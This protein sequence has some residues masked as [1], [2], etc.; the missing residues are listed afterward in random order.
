MA[1]QPVGA[2]A[3][4]RHDMANV[5]Q[6]HAQTISRCGEADIAAAPCLIFAA[7]RSLTRGL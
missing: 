1:L 3:N 4:P 6:A 7:G 2:T 5:W